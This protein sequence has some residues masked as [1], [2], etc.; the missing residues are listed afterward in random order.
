MVY[1]IKLKKNQ[2]VDKFKARLIAKGYKQEY[3]TDY[4]TVFSPIAQLDIIRLV[5]SLT[6]QNAWNIF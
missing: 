1:K 5:I 3:D 6:D 4:E 2:E